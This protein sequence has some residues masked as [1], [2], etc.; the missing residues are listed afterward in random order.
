MGNLCTDGDGA[1]ESKFSISKADQEY[2]YN[3]DPLKRRSLIQQLKIKNRSNSMSN[4][5]GLGDIVRG[6]IQGRYK[7]SKTLGEG[8]FGKVKLASLRHNPSK[9]YAIK[10]IPRELIH[11]ID[12]EGSASDD[13]MDEEQMQQLL[14]SEI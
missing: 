1:R 6:N 13:S 2:F 9:K 7:F 14:E 4:V 3:N 5:V 8:A 10:S 12:K 11:K